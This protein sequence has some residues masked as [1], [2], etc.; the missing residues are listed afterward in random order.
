VFLHPKERREISFRERE[1]SQVL[2]R[3]KEFTPSFL[4]AFIFPI[5]KWRSGE[6]KADL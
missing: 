5:K 1:K 2:Q 6:W 3:R 4:T